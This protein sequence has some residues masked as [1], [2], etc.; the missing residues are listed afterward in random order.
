MDSG[1]PFGP[2]Q[3]TLHPRDKQTLGQRLSLV[4]RAL[5]YGEAALT[6]EGPRMAAVAVARQQ[7]GAVRATVSFEPRSL[8]APNATKRG[9]VLRAKPVEGTLAA[10]C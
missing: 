7:A 8:G 10:G 5:T 2:W 3:G 4:A 1:D 6:F 9:L